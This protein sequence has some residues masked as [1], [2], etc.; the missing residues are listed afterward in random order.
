MCID[1]EGTIHLSWVWRETGDVATNHDMAYAKSEDEGKTWL[2]SNGEKYQL[3][4]TARTA[5]YAARIPQSSELI[6][7]TAISADAQGRPY[8]ATYWRTGDSKVPQ[9]RLIF[10]DGSTWK[11][12]QISDRKTPFSLS[13]GGTRRI[14]ISRPRIIIDSSGDTDKAYMLFRDSERSNRVSAAICDDLS[15]PQ[16]RFLD[17]TDFSVGMW[18]PSYDTELW[19]ISKILHIYLQKVGQ[20]DGET[21]EK[22]PPTMISILEWKP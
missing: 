3:P 9:Y 7:T 10:H 21:L 17:L 5:E 19:K 8:I 2:K 6:N 11:T 18:E 12:S 22:I 15:K 14:P 1:L 13:G 20:G 16:W 4:I